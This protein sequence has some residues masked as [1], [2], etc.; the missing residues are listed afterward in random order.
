M[1]SFISNILLNGNSN[2][3]YDIGIIETLA[4]QLTILTTIVTYFHFNDG[5]DIFTLSITKIFK[6]AI[7]LILILI[8]IGLI[9]YCSFNDVDK[10][11]DCILMNSLKLSIFSTIIL[12]IFFYLHDQIRIYINVLFHR[13]I[14]MTNPYS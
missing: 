12:S 10:V 4:L 11:K 1:H 9:I 7:I 5:R 8:S 6:Y 2:F 3:L 14:G 13:K